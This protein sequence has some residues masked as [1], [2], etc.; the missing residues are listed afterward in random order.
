MKRVVMTFADGFEMVEALSVVDILRRGG[1]EIIMCSITDDLLLT[2]SH[3]VKIQMDGLLKDIDINSVDGI[4]LPG[5][6]PGTTNLANSTLV[7]DWVNQL[8]AEKKLVAA[9]CAAPTVLGKCGILADKTAT[10]YPKNEKDLNA[11]ELVRS[12]MV[13]VD[14]N[15]VT[16]RGMATAMEFGFTLLSILTDDETSQKVRESVIFMY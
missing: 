12:Q 2:S 16:S 7:C 6:M 8:N 9:I 14:E 1:V 15:V 11:R 10:C 4:I 3:Q 13:V 5:G